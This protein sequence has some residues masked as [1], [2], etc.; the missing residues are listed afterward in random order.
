MHAFHKSNHEDPQKKLSS[1]LHLPKMA[2]DS[3]N[4]QANSTF[5]SMPH[6]TILTGHVGA[7]S[8]REHTPLAIPFA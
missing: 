1:I 2:W 8:A 6:S 7:G 3:D 4:A 5:D